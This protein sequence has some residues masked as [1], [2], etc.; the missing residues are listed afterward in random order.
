MCGKRK[1]LTCES[2]PDP[3]KIGAVKLEVKNLSN[4]SADQPSPFLPNMCLVHRAM[5][6]T[7]RSHSTELQLSLAP[8][9]GDVGLL[10][11]G[12]VQILPQTMLTL[13]GKA[14]AQGVLGNSNHWGLAEEGS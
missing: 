5:C 1:A 11:P 10:A 12:L 7:G 13:S 4:S 3:F 9:L 8:V 14:A 2:H 6:Q